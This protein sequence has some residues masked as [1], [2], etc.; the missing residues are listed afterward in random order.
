MVQTLTP[1]EMS[2]LLAGGEVDVV[3]IRDAQE[4]ADG[5]I[6]GARVVPC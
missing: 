1:Q 4:W 2:D 3:D 5:H 6:P